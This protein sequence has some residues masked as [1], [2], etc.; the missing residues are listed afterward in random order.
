M[1]RREILCKDLM[2]WKLQSGAVLSGSGL[3]GFQASHTLLK[4]LVF[5]NVPDVKTAN[6][7]SKSKPS[8]RNLVV[9]NRTGDREVLAG[10]E[11]VELGPDWHRNRKPG[12][13][14]PASRLVGGWFA[15]GNSGVRSK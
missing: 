8:L 14:R 11:Y 2:H 12:H 7:K 3:Q 1:L 9:P 6:R 13:C 4:L 5:R 15:A 10:H